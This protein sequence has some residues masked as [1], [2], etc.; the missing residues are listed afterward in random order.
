M[1]KENLI[2]LKIFNLN[3]RIIKINIKK[4]MPNT[5]IIKPFV[6]YI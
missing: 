3:K 2:L 1:I 6:I 4:I 5:I